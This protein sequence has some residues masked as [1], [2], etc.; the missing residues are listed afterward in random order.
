F[1]SVL[2]PLLALDPFPTRRSSDLSRAPSSPSSQIPTV[3]TTTVAALTSKG[4]APAARAPRPQPMRP[5]RPAPTVKTTAAWL[6]ASLSRYFPDAPRARK[7]DKARVRWIVQT[8]KKATVTRAEMTYKKPCI[9]SREP[10][11]EE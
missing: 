6:S 4:K 7:I 9:V 1:L 5:P 2:S 11:S 10:C 8:V 3:G